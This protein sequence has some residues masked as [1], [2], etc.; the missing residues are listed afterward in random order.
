LSEKSLKL[1]YISISLYKK[2]V[3]HALAEGLTT[4]DLKNLPVS[5]DAMEEIKAVPADHFFST[6]EFLDDRLGPGF[7]VRVGQ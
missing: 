3:D 1:S 7:S 2:V 5:L 6:H 4:D